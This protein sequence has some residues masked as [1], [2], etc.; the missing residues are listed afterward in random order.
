[1]NLPQEV[2]D[3]VWSSDAAAVPVLGDALVS[4][5]RGVCTV[6]SINAEPALD[7]IVGQS[8]NRILG[9]VVGHESVDE[10]ESGWLHEE[11]RERRVEEVRVIRNLAA[12][13]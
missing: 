3:R 9:A 2:R 11:T 5:R 4:E 13:D 1:M 6:L 8:S 7:H 12:E 10:C